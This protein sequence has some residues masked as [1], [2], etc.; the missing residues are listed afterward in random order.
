MHH[1]GEA[2]S[3]ADVGAKRDRMAWTCLRKLSLLSST[4]LEQIQRF[5][6]SFLIRMFRKVGRAVLCARRISRMPPNHNVVKCNRRAEDCAP[7]LAAF[8]FFAAVCCLRA[9]TLARIEKPL[10]FVQ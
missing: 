4:T 7:Y 3:K 10:T 6:S 2:L 1:P 9:Q 8:R 5:M